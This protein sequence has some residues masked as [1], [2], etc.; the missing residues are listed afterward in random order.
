MCMASFYNWN[1]EWIFFSF[2]KFLLDFS[3]S[4]LVLKTTLF[5]KI[6]SSRRSNAIILQRDR[7]QEE[8]L[9]KVIKNAKYSSRNFYHQSIS[10]LNKSVRF[11][12]SSKTQTA[13][14]I[15]FN[16]SYNIN[17]LNWEKQTKRS[18]ANHKKYKISVLLS[19]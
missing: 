16:D 2:L 1:L 18:H 19:G 6:S 8:L 10:F 15:F 5:I 12:N 9:T 14:N 13:Q 11:S 4:K 3:K 17:I 7:N